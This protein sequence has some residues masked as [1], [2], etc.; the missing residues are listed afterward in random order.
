MANSFLSV[1]QGMSLHEA[2][3]EG[4]LAKVEAL[5]SNRGADINTEDD[6][7]V[8]TKLFMVV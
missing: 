3:G 1:H 2:A 8:S 6:E 7:E 4:N 5:V